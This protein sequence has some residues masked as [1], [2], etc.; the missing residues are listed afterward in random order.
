MG[1]PLGAVNSLLCYINY[2]SFIVVL[3]CQK[4]RDKEVSDDEA[5]AETEE[6]K[7]DEE[8]D[9]CTYI[10][11]IITVVYQFLGN[12]VWFKNPAPSNFEQANMA[13]MNR[14]DLSPYACVWLC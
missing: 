7:E 3:Q 4:E 1:L 14:S 10:I 8:G 2:N 6:K 5:E 13:N 11:H 12:S 9:V